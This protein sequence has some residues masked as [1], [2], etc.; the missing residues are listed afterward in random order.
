MAHTKSTGGPRF[1]TALNESP[2][3]FLVLCSSRGTVPCT[4]MFESLNNHER[5]VSNLYE[6]PHLGSAVCVYKRQEIQF[7]VIF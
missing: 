6:L 5:L 3:R 7:F 1:A 2:C 4:V